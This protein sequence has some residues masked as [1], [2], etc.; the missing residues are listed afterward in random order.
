[1]KGYQRTAVK[2]VAERAGIAP[3]TIY[4]YFDSKG[5]LLVELMIRLA[6]LEE[7]DEELTQAL[8]SDARTFLTT[9]FRD[10]MGQALE[11]EE[12]VRAIMPQMLVQP[13][14]REQFYN[15]YV[16]PLTEL[17]EQYV[18]TR[19]ERG[20]LQPVNVALTVRAVQSMFIGLL[21][22]RILGDEELHTRWEEMPDVVSTL[23]FE[24]LSPAP[25]PARSGGER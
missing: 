21:I 5:D 25:V 4:L 12:M 11:H 17:L 3:G 10:R 1:E 20:D 19:I 14:L 24:G 6:E 16:E 2:E 9:V 23:L 13:A 7:L 22:L 18:E 8:Q 15:Q